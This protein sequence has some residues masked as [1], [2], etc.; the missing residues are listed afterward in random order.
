MENKIYT[1]LWFDNQAEEASEHYCR[2]FKNSKILSKNP[3]VVNFELNDFKFMALNG[4]P[5]YQF[6]PAT[7]FVIECE[8]QQEIDYY[9]G[10]LGENGQYNHCGWLADKYG[11]SWQIVPKILSELMSNPEKA[12]KVVEAFLKMSKFDIETLL[13]ANN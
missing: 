11:V 2:I 13:N 8:N 12:P 4:G 6:S 9:W 1:C 7:S 10:K 5:Q 3:I